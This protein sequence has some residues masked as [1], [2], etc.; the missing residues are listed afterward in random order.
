MEN[1]IVHGLEN[2]LEKGRLRILAQREGGCIKILIEDNGCGI[3]NEKMKSLYEKNVEG[4][5]GIGFYNVH[6]RIQL[7]FGES[8][9]LEVFSIYEKGTRITIKLP[10]ESGEELH[11]SD[12]NY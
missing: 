1:A 2:K 9:G 3:A 10:F 12:T 7:Y 4:H 8:F 6:K 5:K 11:V